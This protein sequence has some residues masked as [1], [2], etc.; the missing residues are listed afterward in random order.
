MA[1]AVSNSTIWKYGF[2]IVD[3]FL[4]DLPIGARVLTAQIQNDVPCLWVLVN[5]NTA[6]EPRTFYVIGTGHELPVDIALT[7]ISTFQQYG[8]AL[9]WHLFEAIH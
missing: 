1:I 5:P 9:V 3:K 8:G 6:K 4:L 7:Y 2:D